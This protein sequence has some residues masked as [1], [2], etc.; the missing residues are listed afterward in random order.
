[1]LKLQN[2]EELD[3]SAD[4]PRRRGMRPKTIRAPLHIQCNGHGDPKD[5]NQLIREICGWPDIEASPPVIYLPLVDQ[6]S[7]GRK[8]D[9]GERARF[10]VSH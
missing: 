3:R 4:L 10:Y 1:M 8:S 9:R 5:F 2:I 7:G 6:R